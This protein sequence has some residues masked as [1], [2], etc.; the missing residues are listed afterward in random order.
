MKVRCVAYRAADLPVEIRKRAKLEDDYTFR[1][2]IGRT[3]TVYAVSI[4][5]NVLWYC[6]CDDSYLYFPSWT[7]AG[8]F[9]IVDPRLSKYW[10]FAAINDNDITCTLTYPEWA[11][12]ETDY[13]DELVENMNAA[14]EI[15]NRYKKLIEEETDD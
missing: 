8:L 12:D 10:T 7:P 4:F 14:V 13:Y 11:K 6:I 2:S 9:R 1:V 3:Y 5:W 15:W